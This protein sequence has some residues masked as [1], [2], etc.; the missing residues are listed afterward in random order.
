M[1]NQII[2]VDFSKGKVVLILSSMHHNKDVDNECSKP[3]MILDYNHTKGAVDTVDQMCA[4]YSAQR[5][6][7]RWPLAYFYNTLNIAGIN[8]QVVF[9]ENNPDWKENHKS[10]RRYFL[11]SL[12]LSLLQE[13]LEK[14]VNMPQ[15]NRP[16]I[17]S[18]SR[19]GYKRIIK[20]NAELNVK[21]RRR[22]HVCPT[23]MDVKTMES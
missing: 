15:L 12:G 19:C 10:K 22:C 23:K 14:R 13:W 5:K 3:I 20:Q 9:F 18:L 11:E 7:K 8:A 6:T 1:F 21:K 2:F 17:D 4:C 16:I